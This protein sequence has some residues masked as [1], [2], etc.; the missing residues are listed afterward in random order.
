[1]L[2]CILYPRAKLFVSSGGK[3]QS[4][5]IIKEKVD[6]LCN[7][8]P[9]LDREI[10]HTPGRTRMSKDYCIYM[11]KNKSYFDNL[12]AN[13]KTRGKRRH[14]GLLEECV[15]IDGKILNEIILP[16]M[17]VSRLAMDGESHPEETLNKSQIY[18]NF[19]GR[20]LQKYI[21]KF[22]YNLEVRIN[23]LYL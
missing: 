12:S 20:K 13:E 15:T 7:L 22:L 8:V 2:R 19:F 11:F 18:V 14:G 23:V 3:E 10:D 21:S 5:S 4:A 1:M 16:V 17:N 6:E 9:A